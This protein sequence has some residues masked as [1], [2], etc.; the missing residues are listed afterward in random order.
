MKRP[1][2]FYLSPEVG[3]TTTQ[4]PR[5]LLPAAAI[6]VLAA[7]ATVPITGRSQIA[8]ISDQQLAGLAGQEFAKF[9]TAVN[10]KNARLTR[11]ESLQATRALD[12]VERVSD[13]IIDAA[14]L[15]YRH[16]WE[17][18]VVK[19]ESGVKVAVS[20]RPFDLMEGVFPGGSGVP[21]ALK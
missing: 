19:P 17:T 5:Y 10:Q 13:R 11:S 14:G 12:M 21:E 16:N 15:K 3:G 9:M 7:C 6:L 8:L 4:V 18:V 2:P 20:R 1:I